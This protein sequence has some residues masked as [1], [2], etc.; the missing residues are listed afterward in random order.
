[1]P[2]EA[3]DVAPEPAARKRQTATGGSLNEYFEKI[4]FDLFATSAE[5]PKPQKGRGEARRTRLGG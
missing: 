5:A 3:E 1:M 4:G 2:P